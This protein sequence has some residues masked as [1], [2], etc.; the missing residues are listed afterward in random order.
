MHYIVDGRFRRAVER[1]LKQERELI[2]QKRDVLLE[3]SQLKHELE[4]P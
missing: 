2:R 4:E 1:F 3:R